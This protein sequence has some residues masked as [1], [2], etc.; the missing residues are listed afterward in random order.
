MKAEVEEKERLEDIRAI[1]RGLG[2]EEDL[3]VDDDDFLRVSDGLR[4]GTMSPCLGLPSNPATRS[5]ELAHRIAKSLRAK[6][7]GAESKSRSASPAASG[8]RALRPRRSAVG[9]GKRKIGEVD[10]TEDEG[11]RSSAVGTERKSRA[12]RQKVEKSA[13]AKAKTVSQT[14]ARLPP[15]ESVSAATGTKRLN[16]RN[17]RAGTSASASGSN[18]VVPKREGTDNS[19]NVSIAIA[20]TSAPATAPTSTPTTPVTA[21]ASAMGTGTPDGTPSA[22]PLPN[23]QLLPIG[24]ENTEY[25]KRTFPEGVP[26]HPAFP[27]LYRKFPVVGY[28]DPAIEG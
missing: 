7:P 11:E 24:G 19:E 23:H 5:K 3:R 25:E 8:P 10:T 16:A 4:S 2:K 26:I 17:T 1:R 12:K 13:S 20:A 15:T 6:R 21:F 27:L 28:L 22:I 14:Q 9:V 18:I